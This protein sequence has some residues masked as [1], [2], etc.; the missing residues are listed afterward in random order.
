[1]STEAVNTVIV[2]AK[3]KGGKAK[4]KAPVEASTSLNVDVEE[5]TLE[6]KVE[7]LTELVNTLVQRIE[8]LESKLK[9]PTSPSKPSGKKEK[10]PKEE[11][12]PRAPSAYN[13]F[14]K[15]KMGELKESHPDLNNIERM[16]MAA[17]AWSESKKSEN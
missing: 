16:K 17:E 4:A 12:K 8:V 14:M 2:E 7:K 13:L 11:K 6:V 10:E 15:E 3:K 5:L 9:E 1:M